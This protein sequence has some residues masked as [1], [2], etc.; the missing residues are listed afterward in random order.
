M[1]E[2]RKRAGP[3]RIGDLIAGLMKATAGPKRREL[4]ELS[5][6]WIRAAG[7]EVARSSWPVSFGKGGRLVVSFESSALRQEIQSFRREEILGRLRAEY[8]ARR[9]ADLK[10]VL[11]H[12]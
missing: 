2:E 6:A 7:P 5:E 1:R 4:T 12:D 3:R 10:C 11:R 8:P 9:I